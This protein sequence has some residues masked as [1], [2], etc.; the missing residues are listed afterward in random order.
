MVLQELTEQERTRHERAIEKIRH[1]L[2]SK[3]RPEDYLVVPRSEKRIGASAASCWNAASGSY[4]VVTWGG[5][6]YAVDCADEV[7]PARFSVSHATADRFHFW[8]SAAEHYTVNALIISFSELDQVPYDYVSSYRRVC[9]RTRRSRAS[10]K[11][12]PPPR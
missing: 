10:L 2:F 3:H 5:L 6:S 1:R 12:G 7:G 9:G 4:R 11:A 8:L